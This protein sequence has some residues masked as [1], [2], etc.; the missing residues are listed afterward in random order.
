MFKKYVK[1][2]CFR[3][4]SNK[5]TAAR[6][7]SWTAGLMAI[8][9]E[10][11]SLDVWILIPRLKIKLS[12]HLSDNLLLKRKCNLCWSDK[13]CT[14]ITCSKNTNTSSARLSL[15]NRKLSFAISAP[16]TLFLIFLIYNYLFFSLLSVLSLTAS[17]H[18]YSLIPPSF[19]YTHDNLMTM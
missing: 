9:N 10:R 13:L 7:F 11:L 2:C 8:S 4:Y 5:R 12:T 3:T 17:F 14:K 19:H 6:K 18:F 15:W 1:I 16:A